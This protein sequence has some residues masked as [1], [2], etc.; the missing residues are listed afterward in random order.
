MSL[1]FQSRPAARP[2]GSYI[3]DAMRNYGAVS[4]G[5]SVS[6]ECLRH[7]PNWGE[8]RG[9]K[10]CCTIIRLAARP[11]T[12]PHNMAWGVLVPA[13]TSHRGKISPAPVISGACN[14]LVFFLIGKSPG[15][16]AVRRE[17]NG[18]MW[19]RCL[20]II[21]RLQAQP[22]SRQINGKSSHNRRDYNAW[23]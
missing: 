17:T 22:K 20:D 16:C 9:Y 14:L 3:A 5:M 15:G 12:S 23:R 21:Q 6:S 18:V 10:C 13:P 7:A 8:K 11:A 1:V 4:M 2:S 19:W